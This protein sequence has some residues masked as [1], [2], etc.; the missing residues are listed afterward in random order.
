[1]KPINVLYLVRVW[2]YGGSHS[3]MK[4]LMK[5]LPKERFNIVCVPFQTPSRAEETFVEKMR[6]SDIAIGDERVP[7]LSRT[8]LWQARRQIGALVEKYEID[9]LHT[10]CPQ[11]NV[12]CGVGRK[13]WKCATVASPYGWWEHPTLQ[14]SAYEWVER[15][16]ALPNFERVIT[17]SQNMKGKI[18]WGRTREDRIRVIH[19]GLDLKDVCVGAPRDRVREDLGIPQDAVVVGTVSRVAYEK[20]HT[21][22][23]RAAEQLRKRYPAL[24]ILIVGDGPEKAKLERETSDRGLTDCVVFTGF[25]DDLP[26]ALA[27]MDIFAQPSILDEGFPTS[28]VE[29]EA[30]GL[31][32]VCSD[33]GG[34][35]ETM[36][37]G[38]T[39]LL[40]PKGDAAALR[41]ALDGLLQ[42]MDRTRAM[43]RAARAFVE[44][45]FTLD[46]MIEQVCETYE[47]SLVEYRNTL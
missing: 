44:R 26:G 25:Y 30:S 14:V 15:N 46:H 21:Y 24:R 7:W 27:A 39:G 19:T 47:E 28:V 43:G 34:T 32:V 45:S 8:D 40:V 11:S 1:M 5:H 41:D 35:K 31:S 16:L 2:A 6:K 17:V 23:L 36:D 29:A 4:I 22:L 20:G 42:D 3:I 33:T 18:L 10:H 37:V 12:V 38:A 13:R 9:V